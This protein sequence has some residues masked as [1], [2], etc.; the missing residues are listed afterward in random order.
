MELRQGIYYIKP[1]KLKS[2]GFD[3]RT[4]L[5]LLH[6]NF[7]NKPLIILHQGVKF[8]RLLTFKPLEP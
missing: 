2:F 7:F 3:A 1:R 6:P 8:N 4:A 5:Y